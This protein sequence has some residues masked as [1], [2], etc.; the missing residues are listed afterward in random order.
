MHAR[1]YRWQNFQTWEYFPQM[2]NYQECHTISSHMKGILLYYGEE[3][4]DGRFGNSC[5]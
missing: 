2:P 3:A 5:E 1:S 4:E